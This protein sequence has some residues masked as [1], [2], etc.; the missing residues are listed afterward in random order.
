MT[1]QSSTN[2]SIKQD[3]KILKLSS[4]VDRIF[5]L[6][7]KYETMSQLWPIKFLDINHMTHFLKTMFSMTLDYERPD[8][9]LL[10]TYPHD[11]S[12]TALKKYISS[13]RSISFICPARK[14]YSV[15][16]SPVWKWLL[17]TYKESKAL[18]SS[19]SVISNK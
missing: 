9:I 15:Q 10:A 14:K 12:D 13:L 4:K 8:L 7:D 17:N 11:L 18:N 6:Q 1:F 5:V 16:T 3:K 2:I 19:V